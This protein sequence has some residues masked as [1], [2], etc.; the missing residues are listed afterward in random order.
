MA[1]VIKEFI[2]Y[3]LSEEA[4][5]MAKKCAPKKKTAKEACKTKKKK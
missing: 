4:S 3:D 5:S 2:G 1:I